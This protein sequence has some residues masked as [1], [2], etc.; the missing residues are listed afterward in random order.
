VWTIR[1]EPREKSNAGVLKLPAL[2][3]EIIQAQP[4][5]AS[6]DFVFAGNKAAKSLEHRDKLAFDKLSGVAEWRLHDLR[7]TARSLMSRAGVLSEHAERVLGHVIPG[8]EGVYDR[9]KYFD[10]KADALR[11]LAALIERIV[12][13]PAADNVVPL[14]A[15]R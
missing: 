6:N 13:P 7:R 1:T 3:L 10:E 9:H 5:F 2:A 4:R 15:T 8:V 14:E 11:K 12:D